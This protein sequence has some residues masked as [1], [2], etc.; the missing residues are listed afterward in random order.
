MKKIAVFCSGYGSNF[1][2]LALAQRRGR[3]GG[4]IAV[5][6][7]DNPGAFAVNRAHRHGIPT[8]VLGPKLFPTRQAHERLITRILKNQRV[9]LIALA[10]YMRILTPVF[11]RAW[12]GRILNIHPSLL[13]EFKGAHAIRDAFEARV[14][15]T[16]VS[17]HVVTAKLD[18]GPVIMQKK[19]S[20][21]KN[22]TLASLEKRIHAVEHRLYPKAIK[23]YLEERGKR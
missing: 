21:K 10:G 20:I 16:G 7:C 18:S 15:S 2:A 3:L 11:V 13:P 19:V 6:V 4:D 8:V 14:R 1:E 9:E 22:D 12:R 5:M 17:V 23:K